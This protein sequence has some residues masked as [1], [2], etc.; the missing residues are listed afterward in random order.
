MDSRDC[1]TRRQSWPLAKPSNLPSSGKPLRHVDVGCLSRN[2][3]CRPS[4]YDEYGFERPANFDYAAHEAFMSEYLLVLVRRAK[5]WHQLINGS[6][7][8]VSKGRKIKR[9]VRKGI[10]NEHRAQVVQEK[11]VRM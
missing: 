2:L 7:A 10:P 1:A 3:T 11:N 6:Y 5:R 9:F 8:N 4:C